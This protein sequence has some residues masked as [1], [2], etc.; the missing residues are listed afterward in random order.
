[1]VGPRSFSPHQI[2]PSFEKV[3]TP[4]SYRIK[5]YSDCPALL[6]LLSSSLIHKDK[7]NAKFYFHTHAGAPSM[8]RESVEPISHLKALVM[9]KGEGN[10]CVIDP[11]FPLFSTKSLYLSGSHTYS[12]VHL[13]SAGMHQHIKRFK[14]WLLGRGIQLASLSTPSRS[15]SLSVSECHRTCQALIQSNL[16]PNTHCRLSFKGLLT[17]KSSTFKAVSFPLFWLLILL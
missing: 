5:V 3:W 10:V 6:S 17:V 14:K 13:Y 8:Q 15:G 1:M 4:L 7:L 2:W 9:N 16:L 11:P 12:W